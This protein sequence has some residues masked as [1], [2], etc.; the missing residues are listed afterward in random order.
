M[1]YWRLAKVQTLRGNWDQA[2]RC[3]GRAYEAAERLG[4]IP[5]A[6]GI[7]SALGAVAFFTGDWGDARR[8]AA[9]F[10]AMNQ[11]VGFTWA[12]PYVLID[13]GRLLLAE[14][15][16][17]QAARLLEEAL[18]DSRRIND[19]QA[20]RYASGLLAACDLRAGRPANARDRLVSLGDRPGLEEPDFTVLL[21]SLAS[22]YLQLGDTAQAASIVASAVARARATGYRLIL[23]DALHVQA[24]VFT[25]TRAWDAARRALAEGLA[26]ARSLPYPYGEARLVEAD[27]LLHARANEL[28]LARAQLEA[29]AS[30]FRKLGARM[31]LERA[32]QEIAT[33][34]SPTL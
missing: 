29:A 21:P 10:A 2:R 26:V 33:L 13:Q 5:V 12:V 31:D 22:A 32:E 4:D 24:I 16:D 25:N 1:A 8:R 18:R 28:E 3:A 19:L 23:V 9:Q 34:T 11:R 6:G 20:K 7:A 27:G 15:E 30:A 17:E 14:G